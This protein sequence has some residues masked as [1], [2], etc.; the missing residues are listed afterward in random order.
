MDYGHQH[1][2]SYRRDMEMRRP[3][4]SLEAVDTMTVKRVMMTVIHTCHPER[5]EGSLSI[6]P[7]ILSEAKDDMLDDPSR[8]ACRSCFL[9]FIC[10]ILYSR[11]ESEAFSP[12]YEANRHRDEVPNAID[13]MYAVPPARAARKL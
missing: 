8:L 1:L 13:A 12:I 10:Y 4:N 9:N 6:G 2:V 5:S 11:I 3:P 7:E